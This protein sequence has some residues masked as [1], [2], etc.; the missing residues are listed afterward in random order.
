MAFQEDLSPC[1]YLPCDAIDV[2]LSVG[3]LEKGREYPTGPI[4]TDVYQRLKT[5]CDNPWQLFVTCG[6]H[7][8]TLC[9]FEGARGSANVFVPGDGVVFVCPELILHYISVHW[10]LPPDEFCEAVR[11]CP[12]Q[13]TM[14]Y[15][16]L[17]LQN[18]GRQLLQAMPR[19]GKISE[20]TDV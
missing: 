14:E 13:H 19:T 17:L 4:A 7:R 16:R 8:C 9:Q 18:G 3:W 2:V 6:F 15:R 20:F 5:F 10:Y 12:D 11:R 1:S